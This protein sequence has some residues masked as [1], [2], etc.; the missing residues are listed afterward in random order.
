MFAYDLDGVLADTKEFVLAC[1]RSAGT[2]PPPDFWG[3][4]FNEW[5]GDKELHRRKNDFLEV[6]KH[7]IKP[8]PMLSVYK[9]TGGIILTGASPEAARI[10]C[11]CVGI[12]RPRGYTRMTVKQKAEYLNKLSPVQCSENIMFE[13]ME[14][15]VKYLR[16]NTNWKIVHVSQF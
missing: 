4:T 13:D 14:E 2:E 15:N 9:N 6:H 3:K 7:L 1:Y 8:L 12:S 16:E 10:V 11:G 5:S